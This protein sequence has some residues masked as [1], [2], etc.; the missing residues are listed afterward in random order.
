[1]SAPAAFRPLADSGLL[2][3]FERRLD[4]AINARARGVAARLSSVPGVLETIPALCSTL[5]VFDP[6]TT[7]ISRLMDAAEAAVQSVPSGTAESG[8]VLEVPVVYGGVSGPDLEE[9]AALCGLSPAQV[10]A[11]HAGS[12]YAVYM[13]GFTP[14]YPYLG[15][16]PDALRLPR[17]PAPRLRVPAGSVAIAGSLTGIYPLE[18]PGGWRLIGR[19]PLAIYDPLASHPVLLRPGD[20][21]RFMPVRG[22]T[23]APA[24]SDRPAVPPARPILQL[25]SGGLCTTVQ[26]LGRPG[27]RTLGIPASGAMD[28][29]ALQVANLAVGNPRGAAALEFTTPGPVVRVVGDTYAA[30]AGADLPT[31]LDGAEI[32]PARAFRIRPGQV[33][34]FGAPRRGVWAYLAVRGGI[35]VPSILDSAASFVPGALGG[36]LGRRL[37]EGDILG[38][39]PDRP[40]VPLSGSDVPLPG[41]AVILRVITGPHDDW[42][43]PDARA[44]LFAEP[45]AVTAHTDRAGARLEGPMLAHG[46]SAEFL[47]DGLLPGAIQ[48]P[49]GGQPI[50][51]LPDGPTTGGYPTAAAVIGADLRL[52]AQSRP[53]TTL[54]FRVVS[55]EEAV[56]AL[57]AQRDMLEERRWEKSAGDTK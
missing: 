56:D 57:R 36:Y 29:L 2:I 42:L 55:M 44:R 15:V 21:V 43:A 41:K 14:G 46:V 6:L 37:R 19:T 50:V 26:D 18:S 48:V 38:R 28:A 12:E 8:R 10:V 53:G 17:L 32:E 51:I 54:Q 7:D 13:L 49:A 24:H 52:V 34:R 27:F 16:L 25:R 45:F 30:V 3:E 1:V 20:R 31:S 47:S 39:G 23:F 4:E 9:V 22:A 5:V 33:L 11:A 40:A 35:D